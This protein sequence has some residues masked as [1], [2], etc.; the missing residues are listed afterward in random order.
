MCA[1]KAV[2]ERRC[3][4]TAERVFVVL[5]AAER[6]QLAA[7]VADRNHPR[8][9]VERTRIVLAS[10]E[11]VAQSIGVSR[12]TVWRWQQRFA[13]S[14]VEGL[15]RDKTRKPGK[16][17]IAAAIR[18]SGPHVVLSID[19]KSQI[20]ALNRTQ[21]GL[22]IKPGSCQTITP[23]YEPHGTTTLF[24]ALSVLDGTVIG[25]CMQRHCHVEFTRLSTPSSARSPPTSRS[26]SSSTTTP[27][28]NIPKYWLG[29]RVARVGPFTSP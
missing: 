20:H 5:S 6:E 23:D 17:L 16:I 9:Q 2:L 15:L 10:A 29:C 26:T 4:A 24:A 13:E 1:N 19:E 27:S 18:S 14:G 8:K 22:P 12:L 11:R 25:R 7:I 21:P 3:G 28:I